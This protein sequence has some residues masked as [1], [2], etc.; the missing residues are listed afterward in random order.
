MADKC[1]GCT[2]KYGFFERPST[3]PECHR[4]FC[5]TCL[6]YQGKKVKKYQPQVSLEPCVY[7]KRQKAIN[8]AEE[9][10]ILS[11]FQE[12]FYDRAHIEPPIQSKLR[13]DLITR[14][15]STPSPNSA[16][17]Q[18][19]SEEDRALGERLRKLKE[20]HKATPPSYSEEEMREKLERLRDEEGEKGKG[21]MGG[22][23]GG[24]GENDKSEAK[25]LDTNYETQ[26]E[27]TDKLLEQATDEVRLEDRLRQGNEAVDEELLKRFQDLKGSTKTSR[28]IPEGSE[29]PS[30]KI[31]FDIRNLL[32]SIEAPATSDQDPEKLLEDL[33]A[34]QSQ[35]ESAAEQELQS[36]HVQCL[37]SEAH[38]LANEEREGEGNTAEDDDSD[39]DDDPLGNIAYPKLPEVDSTLSGVSG[40]TQTSDETWDSSAAEV[41]KLL[42][43]GRDDLKWEEERHKE[44]HEFIEQTSERLA[45]LR[46]EDHTSSHDLPEDEIVKSKPK[47]PKGDTRNLD[48]TWSY[49]GTP[50]ITLSS[51]GSA[52]SQL[53]AASD[54]SYSSEDGKEFNEEVQTL[55][56]RVLEEAD[57]D[58]RLESSSLN[59]Q[60]KSVHPVH[61]TETVHPDHQTLH[62][63]GESAC[64]PSA[65][66]TA[67]PPRASAAAGGVEGACGLDELPWCCICNDDASLRCHDCDN[68]LYCKKCFTEGHQ[69][70]GLYDHQYTPFE[71]PKKF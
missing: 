45:Q 37:L 19:S 60:P 40:V 12:R 7:C 70:F 30:H 16:H 32:D 35:Q 14:Q 28:D 15:N 10:E 36:A 13:L 64:T 63:N 48:F 44:T 1:A 53:G 39:D 5:Q 47:K 51:S 71:P 67:L 61:L 66:A 57:L 9:A 25:R 6:P 43:E 11:N 2:N 54:R 52:T 24:G 31:N 46:D 4:G 27:Q 55:I 68:D 69:Q 21:K 49:F 50:T 22:G 23:G 38:R 58:S 3:C 8:K 59:Y 42:E 65:G 34:L 41:A 33:K 26:I 20:F 17:K 18:G 56:A 62:S 29:R